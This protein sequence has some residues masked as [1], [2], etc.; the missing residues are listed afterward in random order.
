M[1]NIFNPYRQV[2]LM[3]AHY[4]EQYNLHKHNFK[5][6]LTIKEGLRVWEQK[7]IELLN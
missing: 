1:I 7:R 6:A 5:R 2:E 4:R 3:C